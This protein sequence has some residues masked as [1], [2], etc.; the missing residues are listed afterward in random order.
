HGSIGGG[1][2]M[3][4]LVKSLVCT[5]IAHGFL[6]YLWVFVIAVPAPCSINP[7]TPFTRNTTP[8]INE[9]TMVILRLFRSNQ[10]SNHSSN[11]ADCVGATTLLM[12]G[13][14]TSD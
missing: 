6:T 2:R 12:I 5:L 9:I 1:K 13:T 7:V 10:P 14:S 3:N 11:L 4:A 8:K